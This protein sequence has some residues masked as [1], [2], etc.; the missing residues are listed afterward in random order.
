MSTITPLRRQIRLERASHPWRYWLG[1]AAWTAGTAVAAAVAIAV[2][3]A[4]T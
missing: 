3:W 1:L 4:V 2:V